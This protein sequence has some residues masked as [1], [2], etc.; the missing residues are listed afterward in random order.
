MI[1]GVQVLSA[2]GLVYLND[3]TRNRLGITTRRLFVA[4]TAAILLASLFGFLEDYKYHTQVRASKAMQ[5]GM[6]DIVDTINS[7]QAGYE[8][9]FLSRTLSVPNIWIQFYSKMDPRQVQE[10][11]R[12]W[13]RY[14]AIGIKY[15][16][17]L[18]E[19]I[20]GKYVFGDLVLPD[21]KG[22]NYLVV[23]RPE[24]FPSSAKRVAEFSYLDGSPSY[25]MVDANE[26]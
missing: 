12:A 10:A 3:L 1:P 25:I 7:R 15:L 20:L 13:L 6:K 19:Y 17:Q 2:W 4:T 23:G 5:Y 21:L 24:E 8:K 9:V 22:Q 16:D 11:S 14:E 26:L 18:D